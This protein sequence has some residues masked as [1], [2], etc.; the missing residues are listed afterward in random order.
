MGNI[1][2]GTMA[3]KL[4]G[5]DAGDD[6]EGLADGPAVDAGADLLGELALEELRDAGG[7]LDVFEAAGGFASGVGEDLAVLAGEERGNLVEAPLED[8]AEAEEDTGSP[9]R[10]VARPSR[11]MLLRRRRRRCRLRR[12]WPGRPWPAPRQWRGCRRLQIVRKC[13]DR[14][15]VDPVVNFAQLL[16]GGEGEVDA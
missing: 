14:L 1:H 5:R 2:M 10:T 6:S 16:V 11:G 4:N 7:E 9:E 15:A 12:E 3:G 13:L 8:F